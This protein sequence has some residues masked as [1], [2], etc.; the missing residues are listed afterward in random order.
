MRPKFIVEAFKRG[1]VV[2]CVGAILISPFPSNA[3]VYPQPPQ[4][5]AGA[6]SVDGTGFARLPAG[7]ADY[8]DPNSQYCRF[9]TNGDTQEN[10]IPYST[11][12]EWLEYRA[13]V[14]SGSAPPGIT[15]VVCCR[16]Q[17]VTMCQIGGGPPKSVTLPYTQYG[18]S[19]SVTL[20]CVDQWNATYTDTE[21]WQ[22][23]FQ[24]AATVTDPMA[25][26]LWSDPSGDSY[27]CS[28]DAFDTGCYAACGTTST[29][30]RYDSCGTPTGYTCYGGACPP[31][32]VVT[33]PPTSSSSSCTPSSVANG[34]VNGDCSI[35]CDSGYTLN[36]TT[37]QLSY[38][39]PGTV[40]SSC[41]L[42]T[43]QCVGGPNNGVTYDDCGN[44]CGTGS[45]ISTIPSGISP[46]TWATPTCGNGTQC[47]YGTTNCLEDTPFSLGVLVKIVCN[48]ADGSPACPSPTYPQ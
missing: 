22:C 48:N 32:P 9:V 47:Q 12:Q 16:R 29:G 11:P 27:T 39:A 5:V 36:G 2:S 19:Q 24:G 31:P 46:Y 34:T 42:Q 7:T 6:D 20:T 37:C 18:Q 17:T 38:C 14:K 8:V 25:D 26:G 1:L 43:Y 40:F 4:Q 10:V 3:Q 45:G 23:G 21:V 15:E 35:T 41:G 13:G 33:P 28:P 30:T 44:E